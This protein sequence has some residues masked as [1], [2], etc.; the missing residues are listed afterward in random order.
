MNEPL[1]DVLIVGAGVIGCLT[2]YRLAKSG[3]KVTVVETDGVASGASGTSGGWLTPYSHKN[4][5]SMLELSPKTLELHRELANALPEETG[6]DHGFEETPY[7]RC[8]LTGDGASELRIWQADRVTEGVDMEW[9]SPSDAR[10]MNPWLSAEIVGALLSRNEPT[11][12]SYRL[13]LSAL[14]A[15]EKHGA[16]TVSGRVTGLATDGVQDRVSGVKLADGS[17]LAAGAVLLSM[18]PWTGAAA[19]WIDSPLP[20]TPQRGQMV[21]LAPPGDGDGPDI[22]T[23]LSALEIPGSMIRKRLTD[24]TVGATKEDVGFDRATTTEARDSLL[25]D[26]AKLSDR[27]VSARIS[28]HTA[29]LRPITPDGR[30][31]V[32]KAPKWQNVYVAAGHASEGIHYA[33]VTALAMAELITNSDST[34]DVSALNPNRTLE[35]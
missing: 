31:Y 26:M 5:P 33:P 7:M 18:G 24:T 9:L 35:N 1:A 11:L 16:T 20:I 19:E 22:T 28:G 13:T 34:V 6:I 30:P 3:I 8:A 2:A 17:T 25:T 23:G 27:V 12:D 4:D 21:Y 10:D 14:Q 15:A 32:G 29:C